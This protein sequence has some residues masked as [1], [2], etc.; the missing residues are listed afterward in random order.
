MPRVSAARARNTPEA[1]AS[2]ERLECPERQRGR[3]EDHA[4]GGLFDLPF[5]EDRGRVH[6]QQERGDVARRTPGDAP[7]EHRDERARSDAQGRLKQAHDEE[8][9]ADEA[10][11]RREHVRIERSM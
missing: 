5:L 7:P 2:A 11:D 9:S 4:E 1:R 6:G 8:R 3:H 10:V